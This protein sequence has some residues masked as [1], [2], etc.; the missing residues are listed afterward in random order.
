MCQP[1]F[2]KKMR[3]RLGA[4]RNYS[5]SENKLH[6]IKILYR[7]GRQ[8]ALCRI[9]KQSPARTHNAHLKPLKPEFK[10]ALNE[11]LEYGV[12]SISDVIQTY[13]K[14]FSKNFN[15]VE[16]YNKNISYYLNENKSKGMNTFIKYL[17]IENR[18]ESLLKRQ[19]FAQK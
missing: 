4:R 5:E 10:T 3:R 12:N 19:L 6:H 11:A 17:C 13:K 14:S 2:G 9:G 8:S 16:Y 7:C 18:E 15:A 1:A